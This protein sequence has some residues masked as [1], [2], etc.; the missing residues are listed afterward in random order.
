MDR[1]HLLSAGAG[2]SIGIAL[3]W[4]MPRLVA[5][6]AA[7]P[8]QPTPIIEMETPRIPDR[9]AP[10]PRPP[11]PPR[12]TASDQTPRPA[13]PLAT[14]PVAESKSRVE[15]TAVPERPDRP[16]GV[17]PTLPVVDITGDDGEPSLAD[18]GLEARRS[19]APQYPPGPQRDGIEGWV[20]VEFTVTVT[21]TVRDVRM[22]AGEPRVPDFE[23]AAVR[24][25]ARWTFRP[26]QRDGVAVE[27]IARQRFNFRLVDD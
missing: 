16:V 2:A 21:G 22:V 7:P 4:L 11:P 24:A 14:D 8:D 3:F 18:Y 27:V 25:M 12:P 10:E 1:R 9:A 15:L 17:D 6:P 19:F 20:E 5:P 26:P 13:A 23:R